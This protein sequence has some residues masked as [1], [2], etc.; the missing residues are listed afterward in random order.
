MTKEK[1]IFRSEVWGFKNDT[2]GN[3]IAYWNLR[4]DDGK[5]VHSSHKRRSQTG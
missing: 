1:S 4:D 5:M 2:N 3:P